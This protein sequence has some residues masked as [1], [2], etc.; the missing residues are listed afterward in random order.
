MWRHSWTSG[1]HRKRALGIET[2]RR[3]QNGGFYGDLYKGGE[4]VERILMPQTLSGGFG[5]SG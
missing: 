2:V 1:K 4:R 5:C 3:E